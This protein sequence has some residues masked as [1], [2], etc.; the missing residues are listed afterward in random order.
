MNSTEDPFNRII[1]GGVVAVLRGVTDDTLV[2]IATA[3]EE[4]GITAIEVTANTPGVVSKIDR[5]SDVLAD[6]DAVVGAGTV[7]DAATA[8]SVLLAGAE[9]IVT[10]TLKKDVIETANRDGIPVVPGIMTPTEA[11]RA[12]EA[13][14]DAVKLFPAKSVGPGHIGA[15]HGPLPQVTIIPTGGVSLDNADENISAGAAAVGIGSALTTDEILEAEDWDGLSQRAAQLV[16]TVHSA[17][18]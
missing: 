1:E 11:Q 13:G 15:I 4:G 8:R 10:P 9:F 7:L 16:D 18:Q 12:L 14:A 2:P 17:R 6:T 3:L 5:L